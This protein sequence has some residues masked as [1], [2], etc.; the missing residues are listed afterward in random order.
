MKPKVL[1]IVLV[2]LVV[3]FAIGLG[4]GVTRG[5]ASST[6]LSAALNA[7]WAESIGAALKQPLTAN[8]IDLIGPPTCR[9]P[10]APKVFQIEIGGT[11]ILTIKS[12][13]APV[14]TLTLQLTQGAATQVQ[15]SQK[16]RMD[17]TVP[18]TASQ[19]SVDIYQDGGTLT[20]QCR[21]VAQCQVT[22]QP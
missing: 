14:R 9:Q 20:L 4:A 12:S 8:D 17:V 19:Q 11:C 1:I 13:G 7:P 10:S 18:L 15:V 5:P 6:D 21:G 3:L 22:M 2:V 16:D